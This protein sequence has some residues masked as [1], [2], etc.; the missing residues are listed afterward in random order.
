[1][2]SGQPHHPLF[3]NL[4]LSLRPGQWTKN[5]FVF[6]A[7]VFAQ[8]LTDVDAAGRAAAA[9]LIFCALSGAVYL[10]N[11]VFDREQDQ[12]HPLKASRPIA[13]GAVSPGVALTAAL[14]LS[15][16]SMVAA[17]ALRR[18][19]AALA[20]AYL[21]LLVSYSAFLKHI[22]ILDALTVAAGFTLRAA[23]GA[24][25]I[26]VPISH[27]LLV[28][29]TLLALFI[30]LS[31]RRHELTLLT[32]TATHHRPI[33]GAYT[34]YLLDQMI[35]VVTA[36][37]LIAYAF[38]TISPETTAKF[39]TTLLSL[40]IPFPLYGIFRYLYLVHRR[41]LGGS[42]TDLLL[43]DRPLLVCV[44]LWALSVILIVYR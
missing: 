3:V 5:L 17:L 16:V 27:W 30:A 32:E 1:M 19:F 36:S 33:L 40:T 15:V 44:A 25:A 39:G 43:S 9:F 14:M 28:C 8:R 22:V 42:P 21:V 38:Y 6:A 26:F 7:L 35:S 37:T 29:T 34:P 12:R 31:K 23:A 24:A 20:V 41:D 10:V 18:A 2:P 4:L 13:L 11:D